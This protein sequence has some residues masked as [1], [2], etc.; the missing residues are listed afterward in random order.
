MCYKVSNRKDRKLSCKFAGQPCGP[1]SSVKDISLS[2]FSTFG[3]VHFQLQVSCEHKYLYMNIKNGQPKLYW[4]IM[5]LIT[6]DKYI[7][8]CM[9]SSCTLCSPRSKEKRTSDLRIT[10]NLSFFV[11]H[12]LYDYISVSCE[13]KILSQCH[14]KRF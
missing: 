6:F 8:F 2:G 4:V 14:C 1:F 10:N 12:K 7:F 9:D 11:L 5:C 13:Y 3:L